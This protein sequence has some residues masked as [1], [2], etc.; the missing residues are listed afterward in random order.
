VQFVGTPPPPPDEEVELDELDDA[1]LEL[2]EL[3]LL[4]PQ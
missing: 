4:P 1:L 3:E 2:D